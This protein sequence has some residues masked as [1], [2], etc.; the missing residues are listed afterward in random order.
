MLSGRIWADQRSPLNRP[1][2]HLA[3]LGP[4]FNPTRVVQI[5]QISPNKSAIY[6][7]ASAT[8]NPL[9]PFLIHP[10]IRKPSCGK[11]E[12]LPQNAQKAETTQGHPG[13][14][15]T[16]NSAR[17]AKTLPNATEKQKQ[18]AGDGSFFPHSADPSI[19]EIP[20]HF[21]LPLDHPAH[22]MVEAFASVGVLSFDI[23]FTDEWEK[24]TGFRPNQSVV[25]LQNSLRHFIFR[26][27]QD[28][29]VIL[30]PT[31]PQNRG[32]LA[33]LDDVKDAAMQQQLQRFDFLT[34]ETS[35]GNRQLW[36]AIGDP[37]PDTR[38]RLKQAVG[39]DPHASGAVRLTGTVNRKPKYTPNYPM[40]RLLA[41]QPGRM[42]TRFELEFAGLL[43]E[44]REKPT[45]KLCALMSRGLLASCLIQYGGAR[46]PIGVIAHSSICRAFYEQALT[47]RRWR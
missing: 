26:A 1:E 33:Q 5:Q 12:P 15:K 29:N 8:P 22:L 14:T 43:P 16:R 11:R 37:A 13:K 44:I 18:R 36:L 35:P 42:V 45:P 39:A 10:L 3:R 21:Y 23:S 6:I 46:D 38:Q 7:P 25:Q 27:E 9:N 24:A 17:S 40:V 41:R 28:R 20:S 47:L 32:V 34:I 19:Y 4:H 2:T 31:L 30:R